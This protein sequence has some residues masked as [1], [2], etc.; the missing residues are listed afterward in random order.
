MNDVKKIE[1][2]SVMCK[3][4]YINDARCSGF[5]ILNGMMYDGIIRTYNDRVILH[6]TNEISECDFLISGDSFY[7]VIFEDY[8]EYFC[9]NLELRK[10]KLKRLGYVK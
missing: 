4:D 3:K 9:S 8:N 5:C 1:S 6:L 10:Y 2:I 7:C